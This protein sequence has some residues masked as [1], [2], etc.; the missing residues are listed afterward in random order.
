[1]KTL[2]MM[3]GA[4]V[5]VSCGTSPAFADPYDRSYC[6]NPPVYVVHQYVPV[7]IP[8]RQN[9]YAV[10]PGYYNRPP[11][12]YQPYYP[13]SSVG[14]DMSYSVPGLSIGIGYAR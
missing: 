10:P 3:I 7:Y 12:Y 11:V 2:I 1:M 9:I 13:Q 6:N 8:P 4:G 14:I 5:M